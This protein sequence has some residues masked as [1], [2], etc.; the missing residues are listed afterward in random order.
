M[1]GSKKERL[2]VPDNM[3]SGFSLPLSSCVPLGTAST[4]L[5]LHS[6]KGLAY[7][8]HLGQC[9]SIKH[10]MLIVCHSSQLVYMAQ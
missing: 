3:E 1:H 7:T 6:Q 8:K 5:F 4:F 9:L 10:A 2:E